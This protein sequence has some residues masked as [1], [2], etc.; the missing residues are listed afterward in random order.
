MNAFEYHRP[1]T[2][3]EASALL[4][5]GPAPAR[6]LAGGTDLMVDVRSGREEPSTVIS[7]RDVPGLDAIEADGEGIVIGAR[8]FLARLLESDLVAERTP[9]LQ[10][11]ARVMGNV[12]IR[13]RATVAGNLCSASPACDMGGPML[14]LD[15]ALRVF[16]PAGERRVPI[17]DWFTGP[18]AT[19]LQPGELLVAIHVPRQAGVCRY[20]RL[21]NRRTADLALASS[22]LRVVRDAD[23][24]VTEARV[25]MGAVAP[26]PR[27]C[28]EAEEALVGSALDE[29]AIAAASG[30]VEAAA[31]PIDD[32]R[33]S[34]WYRREMVRNLVRRGLA[35]MAAETAG[36]GGR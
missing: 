28:A 1:T 7:L 9:V 15:A 8:V 17:A 16:G 34:A 6:V 35:A 4:R 3:E 24:V 10:Q 33:A 30:A 21:A 29:A 13:N 36:G 12:N 26:T 25:T 20:E 5:D 14:A 27:R 23:G 32:V 31:S 19:C 22:C 18:R 11:T 2:L